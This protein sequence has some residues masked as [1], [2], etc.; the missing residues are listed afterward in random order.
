MCARRS[1]CSR[2]P[3]RPRPRRRRC[4]STSPR[5]GAPTWSGPGR[6]SRWMAARTTPIVEVATIPITLGGIA[7]HNVAN[8]LAA[9]GGARAMG[10]L[11]RGGGRRPARLPAHDGTVARAAQPVPAGAAHDHRGLRPQRSRAS[12]PCWTSPRASPRAARAAPR[13]S[14]RSSGPRATGPTTRSRGSAGSR[15]PTPSGSRS[16]SCSST[17]A[18]A[19]ARASSRTS[20]PASGPRGT[21]RRCPSTKARPRR[22]EPSWRSLPHPERHPVR[23]GSS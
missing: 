9:A 10:A 11:D 5:A 20:S 22:F 16:R 21:P 18:A 3:R 13:R 19:N 7:R 15:R 23:G 14:P 2:S 17:S 1:P 4:A 12:R 6:S 8:A